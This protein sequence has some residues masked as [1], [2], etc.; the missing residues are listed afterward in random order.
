[1]KAHQQMISIGGVQ[2][3]KLGQ[4]KTLQSLRERKC[5]PSN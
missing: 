5:F 1:M 2:M 4:R 3:T